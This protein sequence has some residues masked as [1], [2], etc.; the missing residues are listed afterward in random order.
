MHLI[1]YSRDMFVILKLNLV[2]CLLKIACFFGNLGN[3]VIVVPGRSTSLPA[4]L[5]AQ[6]FMEAGI[7]AGV[8]NVV[9]G[10]E[11]SL[12]VNVA[13]NPH[14]S[15]LTYSGCKETGEDLSKAA[16][17]CRL[18]M[19]FSFSASSVC[20]FIIFDSADL[21]SAVDGVMEM[22]FK[23]KKDVRKCSDQSSDVFL[24]CYYSG[25]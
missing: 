23:K 4:L 5:L 19:T 6:L 1:I 15:Y 8:L 22:A 11:A 16:A 18:P 13:K 3:A 24:N 12:G 21:D 10:S 7:P 9:T 17:G 20:P 14:V 2:L 25:T